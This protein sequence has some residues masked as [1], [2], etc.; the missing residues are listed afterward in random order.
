MLKILSVVGARP[1][2]VKASGL[3]KT[4][5]KSFREVLVHTGQHYDYEMSQVFFD[6]LKI[7]KPDYNLDVGSSSQTEQTA[8]IMIGLESI[9]IK[10]KPDAILVYGDTNSTL[11][12]AIVSSKMQIP[13]IHVEAGLRSFDRSMPEEI[14]RIVTDHIADVNFCPNSTSAQNLVREGIGD[15][16][17]VRERNRS[18]TR[19]GNSSRITSNSKIHV[20]GNLM[21]E[22][23]M[24]HRE[25]AKH[26][27]LSLFAKYGIKRG[28]YIFT[29]VHR[30]SNTDDKKILS[31]IVASLS[32][33]NTKVVWPLHPRTKKMLE[34]FGLLK[35]DKLLTSDR[36]QVAGGPQIVITEPVNYLE[37]IALQEGA[38]LV[39]TDSGGVQGEAY[40]LG[41]PC[42]TLRTT[43]EWPET[44]SAGANTLIDP[45][46]KDIVDIIKKVKLPKKRRIS[47]PRTA[48]RITETL[49]SYLI[50]YKL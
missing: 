42:I 6:G 4:L 47:V 28:E 20:V 49:K 41:V 43:T 33:I 12:G 48:E 11:A 23:L 17:I 7:P 44:V 10:E 37:S 9:I 3:S 38:R 18:R 34:K 21:Q 32:S 13:L 14:N 46:R 22:V 29:T 26:L 45:S 40:W 36:W 1:Q 16:N 35:K 27:Q 31:N 24:M 25:D 8:K 50:T 39:V 5:R 15:G 30:Q 2:F 19:G